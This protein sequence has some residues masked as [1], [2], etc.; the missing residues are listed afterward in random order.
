MV[1]PSRTGYID[2]KIVDRI[3]RAAFVR[4]IHNACLTLIVAIGYMF[5]W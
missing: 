3:D 2:G 1:A 5:P 4:T